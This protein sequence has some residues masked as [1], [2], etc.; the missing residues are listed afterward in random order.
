MYFNLCRRVRLAALAIASCT[1]AAALAALPVV[2]GEPSRT[3]QDALAAPV[4]RLGAAQAARVT[5]PQLADAE[6]RSVREANERTPLKRLAI[7]VARPMPE[8]ARR[9]PSGLDWTPVAGGYAARVAV[10]SPQAAALRL[11]LDL[12]GVPGEVEMVAFGSDEP[13]RLAGPVRVADI[14]DRTTA[15]WSPVT[16]GETQT[17]E[18]FVPRGID[19]ASLGLK[20]TAAS[21]IFTT[22]ASGLAKRVAEIGAS[23]SCNVDVKC[24]GL[25]TSQPFLNARNAVA[26]MVLVDA[27]LTYLC[28]GT[29]LNDT[30]P[31][32][33]APWFYTANHCFDNERTP[34]KTAAQMQAVASTLNTLWFFEAATCGSLAVPNYTQLTTGAQFIFNNA[35][36]DSLLVKLNSAAPAGAF[37]SGWDPNGL[38]VNSAVVAI[39]HPQGDLKKV[40]QGTVTALGTPPVVGGASTLFSEVLYSSGS[41]EAGSSGGGILTFDGTQYLLRGALWGGSASCTSPSGFDYYSRFDAT[42]AQL[43]AYL[44]PAPTSST[45]YTDLWWNPNES[46]WGLNLVQHPSRIIF[47][48]WYTYGA[49]GKRVWYHMSTGS[50][51]STN[52]YTGTI[53]ATSGGAFDA[54]FNPAAVVRTPV[55]TGTLTFSDASNGTWT[56]NINGSSGSKAITRLPY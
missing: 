11:A 3:T 14:P 30:D 8:G 56:F 35:G 7:G 9:A 45:D 4:L 32:T 15:W 31:A 2:P 43:K 22:L 1:A 54:P 28:T 42:Y 26:Q 27:G 13:T 20:V 33:Q 38:A 12:A 19:A 16:D 44:A 34:L 41:T 23:G 17:I 18:F 47:A 24:S 10:S 37:F 53:Y 49:D 29:L 51:T 46:G 39:T 25:A 55:G 5:L 6:L 36:A 48:V 21:H 40:S 50:W 52:T